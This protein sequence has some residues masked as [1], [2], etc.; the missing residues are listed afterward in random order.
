[1]YGLKPVPSKLKP[2]LFKLANGT[3]CCCI[4][5]CGTF[6]DNGIDG[7]ERVPQT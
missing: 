1:M 5:L 4:A 6:G 3:S 2:V 7:G